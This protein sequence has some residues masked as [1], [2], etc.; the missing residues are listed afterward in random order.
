MPPISSQ[1]V[2]AKATGVGAA[3]DPKGTVL[4]A[5]RTSRLWRRPGRAGS[6]GD[7]AVADAAAEAL[8]A[9][10]ERFVRELRGEL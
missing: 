1:N 7:G 9:G 10:L 8:V 6:G 3:A 4:A 5:A 2:W